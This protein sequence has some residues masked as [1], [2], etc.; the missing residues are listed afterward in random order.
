MFKIVMFIWWFIKLLMMFSF[1]I[2]LMLV[3]GPVWWMLF[4]GCCLLVPFHFHLC[5]YVCFFLFQG[6]CVLLFPACCPASRWRH[7]L[8]RPIVSCGPPWSLL[9]A[10]GWTSLSTRMVQLH[11]PLT[12]V[13]SRPGLVLGR[14]GAWAI[15]SD[16]SART[17][18]DLVIVPKPSGIW[19]ISARVLS[20]D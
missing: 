12:S 19:I 8:P 9:G 4:D 7:Q 16:M 10:G 15:S 14:C 3:I 1:S 2:L 11:R 5:C 20:W 18:L 6:C 17:K 13:L